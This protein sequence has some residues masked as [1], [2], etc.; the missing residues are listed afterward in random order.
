[1]NEHNK[2]FYNKEVGFYHNTIVK[3]SKLKKDNDYHFWNPPCIVYNKKDLATLKHYCISHQ[4][5]VHSLDVPT[6]QVQ[7]P[8]Y[9]VTTGNSVTLVCTVSSSLPITFPITTTIE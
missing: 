1:V 4:F 2:Y 8:S 7:Q 5:P 3:S 9:S 6:V